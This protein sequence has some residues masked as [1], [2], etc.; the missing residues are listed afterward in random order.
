MIFS[1]LF[2][3]TIYI[4]CKRCKSDL[5]HPNW[6]W[7]FPGQQTL[8]MVYTCQNHALKWHTRRKESDRIH[9]QNLIRLPR[10]VKVFNSCLRNIALLFS[11]CYLT[12][13]IPK[14]W[15]QNLW[16]A[17]QESHWLHPSIKSAN[18]VIIILSF[19]PCS[20]TFFHVFNI[21]LFEK[22]Y[23]HKYYDF[24]KEIIVVLKTVLYWDKVANL[25]EGSHPVTLFEK[26]M[27][28][29]SWCHSLYPNCAAIGLAEWGE[30]KQL[31]HSHT[32]DFTCW[33][34]ILPLLS[35]CNSPNGMAAREE[36]LTPFLFLFFCEQKPSLSS[37]ETTYHNSSR[38]PE[39]ID[40]QEWLLHLH[41]I[42]LINKEV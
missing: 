34:L 41:W 8:M 27:G 35:L 40:S 22:Y 14:I 16:R 42:W 21:S 33:C 15:L 38:A 1:Y 4:N 28:H 23:N 10:A 19:F 24:R 18:P 2:T 29:R 12:P 5:H 31:L 7:G 6:I 26:S 39:K 32:C 3:N 11:L 9:V 13:N 17:E 36:K 20:F 30:I 25:L 37:L